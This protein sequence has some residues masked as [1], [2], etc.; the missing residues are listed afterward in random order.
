M[1]RK[2][3]I[4]ICILYGFL[5]LL[6]SPT[7]AQYEKIKDYYISTDSGVANETTYEDAVAG[8]DSHFLVIFVYNNTSTNANLTVKFELTGYRPDPISGS[9]TIIAEPRRNYAKFFLGEQQKDAPEYQKLN[10]KLLKD[11]VIVDELT[12]YVRRR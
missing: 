9:T 2:L 1:I 7:L 5:F 10:I 3:L 4:A 6:T 8:K 11:G 12:Q